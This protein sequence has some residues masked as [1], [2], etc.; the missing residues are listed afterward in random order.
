MRRI[1]V[2]ALVFAAA[3]GGKSAAPAKVGEGSGTGAG[4]GSGP[5]MGHQGEHDDMSPELKRF[6]DVFAP[7]WHAEKGAKR[8]A[9]TCAAVPELTASADAIGKATPPPSAMADTWTKGTRGLVAAVAKL[10]EACKANDATKF[11]AAF[12]DVHESFHALMEMAHMHD[13]GSGAEHDHMQ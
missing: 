12:T 8:T 2:A 4:S 13:S 10:G 6:R 11:E 3:C 1:F 5:M 9:D 7:L